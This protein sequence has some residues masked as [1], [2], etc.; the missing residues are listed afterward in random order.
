MTVVMAGAGPV[1]V[2]VHLV[3]LSFHAHPSQS[4]WLFGG[5]WG[6]CIMA[7]MAGVI[8]PS[9]ILWKRLGFLPSTAE[10]SRQEDA[11]HDTGGCSG[12]RWPST[13][14]S[15]GFSWLS[16]FS[17]FCRPCL[18]CFYSFISTFVAPSLSFPPNP[19]LSFSFLLFSSFLLSS[20]LLLALSL[21]L[22]S[23][24]VLSLLF[25]LLSH[26]CSASF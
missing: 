12:C 23:P 6:T 19:S 5:V 9:A 1:E 26:S 8:S 14:P 25:C 17:P 16:C 13:V 24:L 3:E 20:L 21:T 15:S 11:Y 10:P 7:V 18:P 4:E 2:S 22:P